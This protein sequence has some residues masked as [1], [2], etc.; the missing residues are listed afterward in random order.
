M[1]TAMAA[2]RKST[3][4][5]TSKR[6][7]HTLVSPFGSQCAEQSMN[8]GIPGNSDQPMSVV[9]QASSQHAQNPPLLQ[10]HSAE[11]ACSSGMRL[12]ES[13]FC[14]LRISSP[15]CIPVSQWD[16]FT[17]RFAIVHPQFQSLSM[18]IYQI[19]HFDFLFR[20]LLLEW[21]RRRCFGVAA[22]GAL[23]CCFNLLIILSNF[24]L[25]KLCRKT[26]SVNQGWQTH[27]P[28][29]RHSVRVRQVCA[30]FID[31]MA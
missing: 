30:T 3:L 22:F 10:R 14:I 27:H 31:I 7:S 13:C 2:S 19:Q 15:I 18:A 20:C 23:P 6:Q 4:A 8:R 12:S 25:F 16:I 9:R 5:S 29:L 24:P 21:L 11:Y 26:R 1:C 17:L 28:D